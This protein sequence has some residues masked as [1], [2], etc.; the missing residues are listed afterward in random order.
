M[1]E[2]LIAELVAALE[3]LVGEELVGDAN[4]DNA[5]RETVFYRSSISWAARHR[6]RAAIAKAKGAQ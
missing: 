5:E 4:P 6:A 1:N 3:E 2:E